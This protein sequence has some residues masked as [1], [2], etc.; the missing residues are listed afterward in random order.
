[1]SSVNDSAIDQL[2]EAYEEYR[3][4]D[5]MGPLSILQ[6]L[7]EQGNVADPSPRLISD[8]IQ[9]DIQLNWMAWEKR[10]P[11][12]VESSNPADLR[13]RFLQIP[14]LENYLD[15]PPWSGCWRNRRAFEA[16]A[17]CEMESR[18]SWGDAIGPSYY[19][20]KHGLRLP[21]DPHHSP[22]VVFCYFD[23]SS[24]GKE[25]FKFEFR[26]RT[27]IG[28]QRSVDLKQLFCDELPDGNRIVIA[29]RLELKI[30][31]EQLLIELLS[32]R[33]AIVTNLS[34]INPLVTVGSGVLGPQ[35]SEVLRIPFGLRLPNRRLSFTAPG[36]SIL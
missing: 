29:G 11:E 23:G 18:N 12:I 7:Q 30:S 10:L 36:C 14:R 35:C 5:R 34:S 15:V 13:N 17:R 28:R 20:A 4:P 27:I 24:D 16:I 21:P 22:N 33:Y 26:G 3:T 2:S 32:K 19:A 25:V 6:F 9:I 31:R 1:M 8:L